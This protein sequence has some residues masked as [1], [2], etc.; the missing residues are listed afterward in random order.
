MSEVTR[1]T[2]FAVKQEVVE[3]VPVKP[4]SGTDGYIALQEGFSLEP[5][6]E[7]LENS[8][9][10][11]GSIG[12]AKP[13][14]G[15][16][17]PTASISAY[18]RASGSEGVAPDF[19][20][21]IKSC[22]GEEVIATTEYDTVAGSTVSQIKVDANEGQ[23]FQRGQ[24]LLIKDAVNG[25]SVRNI[26]SV[27]NDNLNLSFNLNTA[28]A[29]SVLLGKAVLYKPASTHSSFSAWL[30]R[31]NGGAIELCAG[32][33]TT[34]M[35]ISAEAGN[36]ITCDFSM[37][38]TQYYFNPIE[39]NATNNKINFNEGGSEK[40]AT[41]ASRMYKDPHQLAQE[42]TNVMN[43][44]A[45]ATI[46]CVYSDS[47]G[48]FTIS[49]NGTTLNLLWKTGTNGSDN[50]DTHVGTTLGFL[51]NA[52][53]TGATSYTSD[54]AVSWSSYYAASF[55]PTDPLI[56]KSNHVMLGDAIN[57]TCFAASTV[58]ISVTN[59]KADIKTVC[60]DSGKAGS[61]FNKRDISIELVALL[62]RNNADFFKKFR[63]GDNVMFSYTAGNKVG[64]NLEAGK[65]FNCFSP[66]A[67][68]TSFSLGDSD[69]LVTLNMTLTPYVSSGLG[70][71]FINFL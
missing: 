3:G 57:N 45:T 30:F 31:G 60:S 42:I 62:E 51:D 22:L 44:V 55:D 29:A 35:S 41:I 16:E 23:F 1:N 54:N 63:T 12:A 10:Q 50:T 53:D 48:K 65:I 25:Y 27:T 32:M 39:I 14:L 20:L 19:G 66:T 49:T 13:V 67:T 59:T 34:E 56:A 36:F 70:E 6:F 15:T 9:L 33:K 24:A 43:A 46:T 28:P 8:E 64:L 37:E 69:G 11:A 7:T 5:S 52:D 2:V 26:V 18:L 38:G 40:T 58:N 71:F 61:I 4:T 68:I 17:N 21:L 47:T